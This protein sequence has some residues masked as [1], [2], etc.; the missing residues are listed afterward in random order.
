[1]LALVAHIGAALRHHFVMR[2][3]M[4]ARMLPTHRRSP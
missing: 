1:V 4:L 2:D 3:S